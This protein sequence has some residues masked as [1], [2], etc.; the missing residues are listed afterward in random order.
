LRTPNKKAR[1]QTAVRWKPKAC[2]AV[3]V[4]RPRRSCDARRTTAAVVERIG[5]LAA[6]HTDSQIARI[7]NEERI[8]P[9]R[10]GAFTAGK[11]QWVRYA[12]GIA[13]G[14][15]AAPGACAGG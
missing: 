8:T 13:S 3:T 10:G 7:L 14:C 6:N 12:Y 2:P 1:L 4:A 5:A 9:G 11:V 15:P